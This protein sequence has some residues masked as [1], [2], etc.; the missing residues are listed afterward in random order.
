MPNFDLE[1]ELTSQ[2][3]KC[4]AGVDEVG[5]GCLAGPIVAAAVVFQKYEKIIN[6]L[7]DINDSKVLTAIKREE[8]SRLIKKKAFAFGIGVV[9]VHEINKFGIGAA[10]IM[11][12]KRAL[13]TIPGIDFVLIDGRK[14]RGFEYPFRCLEKGESKS[15]SIAAASIIAKVYRDDLMVKLGQEVDS[16]YAFEN[17][18]GYACDQHCQALRTLGPTIHH[19]K[20]YIRWLNDEAATLFD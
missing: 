18:K 19:R 7:S 17:N 3:K 12:F 14:F 20:D 15:I 5:R 8:L 10:N 9:E 6:K 4:V 2:G 1:L 13:D 16:A 11:A